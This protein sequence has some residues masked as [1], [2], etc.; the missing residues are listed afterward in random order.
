MRF[1]AALR[2]AAGPAV[3]LEPDDLDTVGKR[4][5]RIRD[6]HAAGVIGDDHVARQRAVEHAFHRM[7]DGALGVVG[8]HDDGGIGRHG[9]P[10]CWAACAL[11]RLSDSNSAASFGLD[12]PILSGTIQRIAGPRQSLIRY[13]GRSREVASRQRYVAVYSFS[14]FLR[15]PSVRSR[16]A[17]S[18]MKPSRRAGRRRPR[19]PRRS[20]DPDRRANTGWCGRRRRRCPCRASAA[21]GR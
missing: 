5:E 21:R 2:A 15:W 19:L 14:F 4:A 10:R 1:S 12:K 6:R 7:A 20:P 17:L 13:P 3:F 9:R 8:G 11:T 18:L 16:N